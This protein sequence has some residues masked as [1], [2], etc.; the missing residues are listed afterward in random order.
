MIMENEIKN[1]YIYST[2]SITN[3]EDLKEKIHDIHNYMRNNGIGYGLNSLKTFNVLYGLKKIQDYNL[4]D[5][6]K[7]IK[8]ECW[9]KSK[10]FPAVARKTIDLSFCICYNNI[11]GTGCCVT[12]Y[13]GCSPSNSCSSY[14]IVIGCISG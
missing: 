1:N 4:Y 12:I 13:I 14:R 11:L 9:L 2:M 3:R 8:E 5:K 7:L 10:S 6:L